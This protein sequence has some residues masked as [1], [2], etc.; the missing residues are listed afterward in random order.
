MRERPILFSAPMVRAIL[1]GRKTQTRRVVKPQ[2]PSS[3]A[4]HH[5]TGARYGWMSCADRGEPQDH[6]A[7]GPVGVV[8]QLGGPTVLRCPYGAPG[9]LLWVRETWAGGK[10]ADGSQSCRVAYRAD[11]MC[12]RCGA[13]GS[14]V[15]HG[16]LA[17][18]T[19]GIRSYRGKWRPSI[20][21]PRWASRITL[22]VTG[23]RVERLLEITDYA[24]QSEGVACPSHDVDGGMCIGPRCGELRQAW[25][26][27]WDGI[28][29]KRGH[30][31]ASNPWVWV[32]EFRR[33]AGNDDE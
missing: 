33:V 9:D 29:A 16:Y 25:R 26:D 30:S 24:I 31:W 4:V 8:H 10:R 15:I 5:A 17:G 21:M 2:P 1:D 19:C 12:V 14:K 18:D 20:H 27:M 3:D 7:I 23:V 13:D 6:R 11:G 32:V 22:E 28:N